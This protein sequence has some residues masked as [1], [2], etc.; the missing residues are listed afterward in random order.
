MDKICD[1]EPNF[2]KLDQRDKNF[3]RLTI[4]ET[5]RRNIQIDSIIKRFL[6]KPLEYKRIKIEKK[7]IRNRIYTTLLTIPSI[8]ADPNLSKNTHVPFTLYLCF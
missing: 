4:L 1:N 2:N 8:L 3:V 5:L 7:H 6:T